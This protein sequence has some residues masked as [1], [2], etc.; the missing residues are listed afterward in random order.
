MYNQTFADINEKETLYE[1]FMCYW[2]V[3]YIT[4]DFILL[5]SGY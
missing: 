4:G 2:C 3:N 5:L 1:P